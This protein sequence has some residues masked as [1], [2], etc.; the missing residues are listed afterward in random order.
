MK[1]L[2]TAGP[3]REA[4]DPVRF[5]SN[6][7]S[8]K[9]GYAIAAAAA[10]RGHEV[11]LV[12]G[13]VSLQPAANMNVV[14]VVTADQMRLAVRRHIRWC[15]ALVMSAAVADWRPAATAVKKIKKRN[16]RAL[17]L[18]LVPTVDILRDVRALKGRR[19][20]V[21]FAAET[22][23]PE[24]D[25]RRKRKEKGLDLIVANNVSRQDSGFETDTNR[26]ILLSAD[27][28]REAWPLMTKARV[29]VRLVRWIEQQMLVRLKKVH[30][31]R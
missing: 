13:P 8:G 15:D 31:K 17:S 10:H 1:I 24:K 23:A 28:A 3:T 18:K 21:G 29:G 4:I 27:G 14:N 2:V 9:M 16:R 25:A 30:D 20:Y 22:G 7:S 12:S 5:I 19:I 26:V 6:R 11:T